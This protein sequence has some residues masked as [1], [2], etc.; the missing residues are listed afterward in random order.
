MTDAIAHHDDTDPLGC[1]IAVAIQS[2]QETDTETGRPH[3]AL[4]REYSARRESGRVC[5]KHVIVVVAYY[6]P[7]AVRY[8]IPCA[9]VM[10][11]KYTSSGVRMPTPLTRCQCREPCGSLVSE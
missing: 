11:N 7:R 4:A 2:Q 9:C 5:I 10:Y 1:L 8:N 3:V 6:I